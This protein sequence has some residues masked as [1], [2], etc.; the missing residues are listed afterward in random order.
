MDKLVVA[1]I[2]LDIIRIISYGI[3]NTAITAKPLPAS[4]L[5]E[6]S[7]AAFIAIRF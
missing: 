6:A 4:P 2:P 1:K 7:T 5:L 3:F